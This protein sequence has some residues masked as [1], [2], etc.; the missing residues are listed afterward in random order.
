MAYLN[1]CASMD[2]FNGRFDAHEVAPQPVNRRSWVP[3]KFGLILCPQRFRRNRFSVA[4]TPV[5][6]K[7]RVAHP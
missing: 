5:A 4:S 2:D 7:R 1:E 3:H 6:A